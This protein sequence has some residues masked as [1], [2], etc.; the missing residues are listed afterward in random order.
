MLSSVEKRVTVKGWGRERLQRVFPTLRWGSAWCIWGLERKQHP[1]AAAQRDGTVAGD[2]VGR[3]G[4]V[5]GCSS[6]RP[7][8]WI[9]VLW[10]VLSKWLTGDLMG[11][12]RSSWLSGGKRTRWG[13]EMRA[14][15]VRWP[16]NRGLITGI[17][18]TTTKKFPLQTE[19][20]LW[21]EAWEAEF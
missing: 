13:G 3:S 16:Q 2:T 4:R 7:W 15:S 8:S 12:W 18:R 11:L 20:G 19:Q 5:G 1:V 14:G 21:G 17:A 6:G 10:W 9:W